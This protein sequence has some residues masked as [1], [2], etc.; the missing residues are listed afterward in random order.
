MRIIADTIPGDGA[1]RKVSTKRAPLSSQHGF[2][3]LALRCDGAGIEIADLPAGSG[4]TT[5][6]VDRFL[7]AGG[8]KSLP[9]ED[10]IA[11]D[12]CALQPLP[13]ATKPTQAV[14]HVQKKGVALLFSVVSDV[15]A[16]VDLLGDDPAQGGL[17]RGLEL[18][19]RHRFSARPAR[20]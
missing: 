15:N 6:V 17:P 1:V 10:R 2:E 14:A 4:E 8:L 7:V 12:I 16:H 3:I 11:L 9:L 20:V 5:N 19:R 13:S 18:V